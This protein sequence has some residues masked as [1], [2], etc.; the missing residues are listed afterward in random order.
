MSE[1]RSPLSPDS[2]ADAPEF[3]YIPLKDGGRFKVSPED[4]EWVSRHTWTLSTDGHIRTAADQTI[5]LTA[6]LIPGKGYIRF[7]D[8]DRRNLTRPNLYRVR[9]WSW[10]W[11]RN[12]AR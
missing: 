1:S 3:V 4:V 12:R 5:Q 2:G 8:N 6:R 11:S 9:P 7:R 10:C